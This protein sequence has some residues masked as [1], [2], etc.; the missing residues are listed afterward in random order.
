MTDPPAA[1]ATYE[2]FLAAITTG[3]SEV[4]SAGS[5]EVA[6]AGPAGQLPSWLHQLLM[7]LFDGYAGYDAAAAARWGRRIF[8]ELHRTG[9]LLPLAAVH[10]WQARTVVPMMRQ[11]C[12]PAAGEPDELVLD[13]QRLHARAATGERFSD[14]HWLAAL[15]PALRELYRHAYDYAG[16]HATA[17]ASASAYAS[18][19]N[20]SPAGAITFADSY[21]ELSTTANQQSFAESNAGAN[22][23]VLA[24]A[25]AS[26][27]APA[28]AE[29]YPFALAQACAHAV[30]NTADPASDTSQARR[31]QAACARLADGLADSL[32]RLG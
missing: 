16:A 9:S 30:A 3:S 25:Y 32:A 22:A 2:Q 13:L 6:P 20:F 4:A 17:H 11:A 29:T 31:R 19:N 10:D 21:A 7:T 18:A 28:Y 15:E 27:D 5:P 12:S 23:A 26:H 8:D 1:A 14:E 24:A